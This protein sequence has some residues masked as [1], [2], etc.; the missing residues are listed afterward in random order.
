[1]IRYGKLKIGWI[2]SVVRN[3]ISNLDTFE[4]PKGL[5]FV[6]IVCIARL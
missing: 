4:V 3:F 6:P 2:F 5:G 1:M